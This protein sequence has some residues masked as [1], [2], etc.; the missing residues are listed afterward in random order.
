MPNV[1]DFGAVGDGVT[2]DTAAL[3]RAIDAGGIVHLPAGTYVSGTLYLKSH[4]GLEL[5]PGA[6]LL[7]SPD[8]ADYNPADFC[9]QNRAFT[10]EITHGGHLIVAVEQ[11]GITLRGPGRID[12]HHAAFLNEPD[13]KSPVWYKR[14]WRPSQMVFLCECK[15]VWVEDIELV[16]SPYWTCFLHGCDGVTIRGVHIDGDRRVP[17][18][19]GIDIDCCSWVTVSDCLVRCADD[20][21]TLRG[22]RGPLKTPRA[23]EHI[24]ISNCVLASGY[25]NGIR[26]GVGDGVVRHCC[27]SNIAIS[28]TRTAVCVVSKYNPRKGEGVELISDITFANL[29][30]DVARWFNI[31]LDNAAGFEMP[32]AKTISNLHFSQIRGRATLSSYIHG[33]GVGQVRNLSFTDVAVTYGG[34]GPCPDRTPQ[35]Y[36]GHSSTDAA[37]DLRDL[38]GVEFA[39]VRIGWENENPGWKHDVTATNCRDFSATAC[40]FAKGIVN[41]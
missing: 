28:D 24:C 6:V 31:K 17:N 3:Q 5:H 36:W 14:T 27:F 30:L 34:V 10:S 25:A 11:E 9:P 13:P 2:K 32:C 29:Q 20:C 8:P 18:N 1:R 39:N 12:G 4:G 33:N 35:G 23:C 15:N 7:A 38:D 22:N 19:D 16:N 37:F 40:R 41:A 21:L 26:I